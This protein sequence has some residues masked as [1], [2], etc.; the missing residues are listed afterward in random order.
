[1]PHRKSQTEKILHWLRKG[2]KL[3]AMQALRKFGC[4]RLSGRIKDLRNQDWGITTRMVTRNGK[5]IA[6]YSL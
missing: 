2:H 5:R 6:E 4:F 1:M 3:T